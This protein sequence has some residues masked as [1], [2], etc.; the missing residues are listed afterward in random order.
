MKQITLTHLRQTAYNAYAHTSFSP[1]RRADDTVSSYA[2]ELTQDI[3]A[4]E[5]GA[6]ADMAADEKEVIQ[7]RY[8]RKYE[9]MLSAWLHSHA[10]VASAFIV[11]PSKFPSARM[12]KRSGWADNHY[13]NFR[14]WRSRA[15]KAILK[16]LQPKVDELEEARQKLQARQRGQRL[17]VTANKMIRKAPPSL[18]DDLAALGFSDG[19]IA[20][21][22]T[23][24]WS[25]RKGFKP[26][27]LSNNNAEIHRLQ[28]RVKTLEQKKVMAETV[29]TST[30]EI[31]GVRLVQNHEADRVQLLFP[32][33][34]AKET[35]Q[36]LRHAGFVWSPTAKAWQRKLTPQAVYIGRQFLEKL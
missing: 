12:Q 28:Q 7:D 21:L 34:P 9:S 30:E 31:K 24:A 35:C 17:M 27:Q 14:T 25:G 19:V 3:Q 15:L 36:A 18:H 13:N 10:N 1:D 26:Y 32:D 4:I 5:D 33:R 23:P 11:G 16:G 29:G 22:L 20:E 2:A 8:I 6:P